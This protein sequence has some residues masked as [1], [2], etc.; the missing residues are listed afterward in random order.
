MR[1]KLT[2]ITGALTAAICAVMNLLL[3]PRIEAGT[4]GVRCFDMNF[5]YGYDTAKEFLGLLTD[6]GRQIYLGRQLPLDF[7]YPVAYGLF[8][9]LLIYTLSRGKKA[10]LV[11]PA[12]LAAADYIENICVLIMLR[13]ADLPRALVNAASVATSAK[14]ILMYVCILLII[15]LIVYYLKTKKKKEQDKNI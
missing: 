13:S 10:L 12:L 15:A 11:F 1:K 3:I 9:G 14:T 8:F 7:V 6:E 4:G 5:A 2:I